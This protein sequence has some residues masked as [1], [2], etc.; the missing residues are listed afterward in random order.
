MLSF[1]ASFVNSEIELDAGAV[2]LPVIEFIDNLERWVE[3]QRG[4]SWRLVSVSLLV[5][6]E[7]EAINSHAARVKCSLVDFAHTFLVSDGPDEN[8][9]LGLQ[10]LRSTLARLCS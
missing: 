7:G 5:I 2:W 9:L 4:P 3:A 10:S 6:Y 8:F 1:L